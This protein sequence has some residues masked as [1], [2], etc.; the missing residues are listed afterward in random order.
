MKFLDLTKVYIRSGGGGAGCVVVPAREVR[1]IRR[2]GWR[3]RRQWRL[4]LGRG[5]RGAEHAD[6]LPLP[7]AFLR[8]VRPARHG[9]PAHRQDRR[10]HHPEGAGR[11]RDSGR[12]RGNRDRR[13]D[14]RRPAGAAGQ[15]R[16]RRLGQPAVQVLDQPRAHPGQSG[17]GG[18]RA[19]DLAAAEADRRCG[20]G[21]PAECRAS[22]PSW[23][24]CRTRGRRSP[25]IPSPRWCRTWASSGST[26]TNSSWPT[27]PA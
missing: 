6:R 21:G 4:G 10:R 8:Q 7:A 26:G 18:G 15:G 9:Q 17:A 27:F 22:P 1:R 3:R 23:P 24:R 20:A 19:H 14:H 11:H 5:G 12:G 2:P 25:I 16:Q 13:P